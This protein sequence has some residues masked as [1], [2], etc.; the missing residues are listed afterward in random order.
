MS[1]RGT[2]WLAG[3]LL[4][5]CP[6][7]CGSNKTDAPP[8]PGASSGKSSGAV[9]PG[10]AGSSSGG[11]SAENLGG[12]AQ[13][14]AG[15]A[16]SLPPIGHLGG[17]GPVAENGGAPQSTP[18]ECD[19]QATWG[20]PIA[21]TG[22]STAGAD[23]HLLSLTHDE[24]TIVF[25]R[26]DQLFVAD[27]AD[28]EQDFGAPVPL[29]LPDPYTHEQGV[30][31]SPDGLAL[32]VVTKTSS[33]FADVTRAARSG[34]FDSA[35]DPA[36]FAWVNDHAKN[37]GNV[38][39]PV[40]TAKNDSLFYTQRMATTSLVFRARG[41][42]YFTDA[43]MQDAVTLGADDG[44][45]KLGRS[46]SSDE[47]VLFV[48]DEALG[49]AAGLWSA[50]ASAPFTEVVHFPGLESVFTSQGCSRLY[51]TRKVDSSLDIVIE[52]PK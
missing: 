48:Y 50:A 4:G 44:K 12:A 17:D 45:A 27:R 18:P 32:V 38:S 9:H 1:M 49:H 26:G 52:T 13:A 20:S 30:A 7:A 8:P 41:K 29:T 2:W 40:L 5:L 25:V 42:G 51:G 23:E 22:I 31:L 6:S 36:R 3:A 24:L 37:Y 33:A 43:E 47:R 46:I 14:D 34:A 11:D 39:A 16:G 28:A 35:A 15:E 10:S 21:L 19:S